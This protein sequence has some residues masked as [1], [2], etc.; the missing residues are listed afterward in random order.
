MNYIDPFAFLPKIKKIPLSGAGVKYLNQKYY[1]KVFNEKEQLPSLSSKSKQ[2]ACRNNRCTQTPE[3][4][5]PEKKFLQ[6]KYNT[7]KKISF[8]VVNNF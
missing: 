8:S 4:V 7:H 3:K 2:N 5:S 1:I 6:K